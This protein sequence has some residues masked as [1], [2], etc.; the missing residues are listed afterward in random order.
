M[1]Q[2]SCECGYSIQDKDEDRLVELVLQHVQ[3][4]HPDLIDTVTPDVV[5][6]WIE[7]VP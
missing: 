5:R 3:S 6:A 2:V 1:N 4:T 7:I